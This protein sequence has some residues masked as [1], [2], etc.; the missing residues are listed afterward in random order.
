MRPPGEPPP[1]PRRGGRRLLTGV[2]W[3][4]PALIASVALASAVT[5]QLRHTTYAD[6]NTVA[7]ELV[8]GR[9]IGQ[10]FRAQHDGLVAVRLQLATYARTN[11][12]TVV[13]HLRRAPGPGSDLAT[14]EV[15]ATAL[16]D[17]AWQAFSIPT[18]PH[19]RG[20]QYYVELEHRGAVLG[21]AITVYWARAH[22]DP[23][24]YGVATEA[25]TSVDGDLAFGLDYDTTTAALLGDLVAGMTDQLSAT[26]VAR[27]IV[28]VLA[29]VLL[30]ALLLWGAA[31]GWFSGASA[32][33]MALLGA[34]IGAFALAHGAVWMLA[35]PPWQGPDEFSHYAY[36]ALLAEGFNPADQS[37]AALA[38]RAR[39]ERDVLAA[40]D[41]H[42][43]TRTVS[44]YTQ[45]G[46]PPA[47]FVARPSYGGSSMFLETRQPALYYRLGAAALRL[48]DSVPSRTAPDQGLYVVRLVSVL[49]G[50]LIVLLA[51]GCAVLV[52]PGP[53]FRLL[54]LALPITLT[55][56]PMR[57]FIDSMANNDVL[58]EL[59]GALMALVV[60]EWLTRRHHLD[61]RAAAS[62]VVGL[63]LLGFSFLTKNT[64]P[65]A[66]LALLVAA[67]LAAAVLALREAESRFTT[68]L[69]T[70]ILG[71]AAFGALM[72]GAAWLT[73]FD[74]RHTTQGWFKGD[75]QRALRALRPSAPGV[76]TG[77]YVMRVL[78]GENIVQNIE[79]PPGHPV[80]TATTTLW[81]RPVSASGGG[82]ITATLAANSVGLPGS[83]GR[84]LWDPG[85]G[86]TWQPI[87]ATAT[88][89][90]GLS[91]AQIV[92]QA[93][94]PVEIDDAQLRVAGPPGD[95]TAAQVA[96]L[97]NGAMEEAGQQ[98]IPGSLLA[99]LIHLLPTSLRA[100]LIADTLANSQAFD[101]G[102][103]AQRY[104]DNEA[105]S[106]WG[107]FG[108]LTVPLQLPE[109]Q[110]TLWGVVVLLAAAGWVG[111]W[112]WRPRLAPPVLAL[113]LVALA[114]LGAMVAITVARQMMQWAVYGLPDF[115]QGRYLFV[116]SIP[117][118]WLLIA[119][120]GRWPVRLARQM[121]EAPAS[122]HNTSAAL[123]LGTWLGLIG[124][125]FLDAYAL[126]VLILPY[127]YGR[128]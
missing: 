30:L 23:Y 97:R 50:A 33:R 116:L 64:A 36:S 75:G 95:T 82:Q 83:A 81:A 9:R 71:T 6:A 127:Y 29:A 94:L 62:A 86:A 28:A 77:G 112:F 115:P 65:P 26:Q 120:L 53:H 125:L 73:G 45:P 103:V 119:G 109:A 51:W 21:N 117:T 38:A 106:Y 124:L 35:V 68:V 27:L 16:A 93:T 31:R 102:A 126:L 3:V 25:G 41:A 15:A 24:P 40:M 8:Q 56:L 108:W 87:T 52:A 55:L 2:L 107:W 54:W 61:A 34:L 49:C 47:D 12:G 104:L 85:G 114:A 4:L 14:M 58:A 74:G 7:G 84:S 90:P 72:V 13:L 22:G 118:T 98:V 44:W 60:F 79:L 123:R 96:P 88:L 42:G 37:A 67:A 43:F 18:Q 70:T 92:V 99:V 19:S 10:T 105:R 5:G 76:P 59:T 100:D 121:P 20:Q 101:K 110:Y 39:I 46:G 1:T 122:G 32:R 78:P 17:N 80:L 111:G 48:Y 66:V 63:G 69:A 57:A 89:S 128:F 11:T 113:S 91:V